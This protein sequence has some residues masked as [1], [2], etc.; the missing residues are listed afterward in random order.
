VSINQLQRIT[1]FRGGLPRLGL[2]NYINSLPVVLP[3]VRKLV[4]VDA[5]VH[6]GTPAQLNGG[7]AD[8]N[9]DIGAMSAFYYLQSKQFGLMP[10]ISIS[11]H[12]PVGSVLFFSKVELHSN[13]PLRVAAT[14][15]SATS[16]NLLKILLQEENKI[17][18]AFKYSL[19]PDLESEDIDAALVIGD[20]ALA[21]DS[22]WSK[23]GLRIDL[24]EWWTKRY[25]LPMV[26]GVWAARLDWQASD[27]GHFERLTENLNGSLQLGLT[28]AFGDILEEAIRRTELPRLRLERYFREE[29]DY[30]FTSCHLDG[31]NRYK[32]LCTKYGLLGP[33]VL[34]RQNALAPIET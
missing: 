15:A 29:L 18:A 12:G 25:Q 26:F 20:Y 5:E 31:L 27:S 16:V 28:S 7:Y 9:L 21:V 11:S 17:E 34:D 10:N 6:Y 30:T 32:S 13:Q 22:R 2:I 33:M 14:S 1:S 23:M 8:G 19:S 3:I 4:A 24:G